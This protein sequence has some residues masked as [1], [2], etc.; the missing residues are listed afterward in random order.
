MP[1]SFQNND[2]MKKQYSKQIFALYI[3]SDISSNAECSNIRSATERL[4][5][6]FARRLNGGNKEFKKNKIKV[7]NV[8]NSS[9]ELLWC[10]IYIECTDK[11]I[12][13]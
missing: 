10:P 13:I 8:L 11:L 7:F 4:V 12:Y 6:M 1:Y 9:N 3:N 5:L 2:L